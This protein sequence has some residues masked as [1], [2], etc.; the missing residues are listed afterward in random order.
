MGW[1]L[2]LPVML[3]AEGLPTIGQLY[4]IRIYYKEKTTR[5]QPPIS[6]PTTM[7]GWKLWSCF[8]CKSAAIRE[9]LGQA[10]GILI[11]SAYV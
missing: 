10:P 1:Y 9:K 6:S 5:K 3:P 8:M 11:P 2:Q 7:L 4:I